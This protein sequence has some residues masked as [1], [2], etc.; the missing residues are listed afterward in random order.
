[1]LMGRLFSRSKGMDFFLDRRR[2]KV[3]WVIAAICIVVVFLGI[4][5]VLLSGKTPDK[6]MQTVTATFQQKIREPL[7]R[8]VV[9]NPVSTKNEKPGTEPG[10]P[11]ETGLKETSG[12]GVEAPSNDGFS[13]MQD[14]LPDDPPGKGLLLQSPDEPAPPVSSET[15][16][17]PQT[18][19]SVSDGKSPLVAENF[20]LTDK[21]LHPSND[22][23]ALSS[24]SK[25]SDL[26]EANRARPSEGPAG[27][28]SGSDVQGR[29]KLTVIVEVG[30]V[31]EGPSVKEKVAFTVARG[32]TVQVADKK[33]NW[34]AILM[35][36][37]RSGWAHRSLLYAPLPS[38]SKESS[39]AS[40]TGKEKVIQGIR[41][42]VTDPDHAQI[43]F[44]L[45]G[46][47]PPE[48][49]VIEGESPRV[50][51]DFFG[52]RLAPGV[53]KKLPVTT[54]VVKR[55]RVGV[56]KGQKPKTRVVLDLGGGRNYAV[57]QFFFEKENYYAIMVKAGE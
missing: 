49:V 1:M 23:P 53:G 52:V 18:S 22:K 8:Y 38:P 12:Q 19:L 29:E 20:Q 14:V 42:V 54:G 13:Q 43:V 40:P 30:N 35:D 6:K 3:A 48:I 46:Y 27:A 9:S 5:F 34:C 51:C 44:E 50:V 2:S 24:P 4:A 36:D 57:E 39:K 15:R 11:L 47:Y 28:K 41:T 16:E 33:G 10:A 26:S 55:I 17:V 45:N 37:G 7:K 56:H 21:T 25:V 32:D 31:R